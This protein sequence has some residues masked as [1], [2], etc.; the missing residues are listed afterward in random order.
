M[1]TN[2]EETR[3]QLLRRVLSGLYDATSTWQGDLGMSIAYLAMAV[4]GGHLSRGGRGLLPAEGNELL[5]DHM[6]ESFP[7][8]D[9][10]WKFITFNEQND[11]H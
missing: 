7:P 10:V 2:A 4:V 1:S 11:T 8:D 6:R 3:E 9:P 5:I